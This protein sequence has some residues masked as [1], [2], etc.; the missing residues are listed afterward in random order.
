MRHRVCTQ[1]SWLRAVVLLAAICRRPPPE[2]RRSR[3]GSARSTTDGAEGPQ[4]PPPSPGHRCCDVARVDIRQLTRE[5]FAELERARQ[6]FILEH[7]LDHWPAS[8]WTLPAVQERFGHT[9][10]KFSVQGL[11][12]QMQVDDTLGSFLSTVPHS[13]H[14][15]ALYSL[16]ENL[17]YA[18]GETMEDVGEVWWKHFDLFDEDFFDAFPRDLR[19]TDRA[20]IFAGKG[21]ASSLHVDSYNW[22]GARASRAH[23]RLCLL[24]QYDSACRC[25]VAPP[26][27]R[28][29]PCATC[30]GQQ[31]MLCAL[32]VRAGWNGNFLGENYWRFL[33]PSTS[34]DWMYHSRTGK[35]VRK[36]GNFWPLSIYT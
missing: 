29:M 28:A 30:F 21:G 17:A 14:E 27:Q 6:P 1:P 31:I 19:P 7:A 24:R 13:S 36:H 12:N 26:G 25:V 32:L 18:N 23:R 4:G 10:L 16:T 20:F 11:Y 5:Q 15:K 33:P 35:Q 22:T 34:P 3:H 8:N 2:A 9:M